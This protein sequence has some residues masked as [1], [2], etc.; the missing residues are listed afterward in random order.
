[1]RTMKLRIELVVLVAFLSI[2]QLANAQ[3]SI[4]NLAKKL[5]RKGSTAKDEFI[6]EGEQKIADVP[7][8]LLAMT[9]LVLIT[10]TYLLLADHWYHKT[11][12][13]LPEGESDFLSLSLSCV[14]INYTQNVV[15]GSLVSRYHS[16][17]HTILLVLFNQTSLWSRMGI[18][19]HLLVWNKLIWRLKISN[20]YY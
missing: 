11:Q 19:N 18:S 6:I 20:W 7:Y 1:M 4:F 12:D 9:V 5:Q 8:S 2:L 10:G 14:K 15:A 17:L 13:K 3:R 16:Y